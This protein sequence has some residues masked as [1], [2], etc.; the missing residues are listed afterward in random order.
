MTISAIIGFLVNNYETFIKDK[1][2]LKKLYGE[3]P[4]KVDDPDD[5]SAS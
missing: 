1:S 3:L 2:M 5:C 4:P